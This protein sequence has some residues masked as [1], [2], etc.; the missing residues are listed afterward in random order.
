MDAAPLRYSCFAI[1]LHWVMALAFLLMLASGLVM[2][3]LDIP[4]SLQFQIY[5]WHKS[6]GVLLLLA[7]FLRLAV[8]LRARVPEL[9][10]RMKPFE[11][12]AAKAGH[13][14]LYVWMIALPLTGWLVVSASPFG[15]PTIVF[16]WFEW[17]H[18]PDLAGN[19]PVSEFAETAHQWLAYAFIALIAGHVAAV[20]KHYLI[21]KENLLPRMGI[22]RAK[23]E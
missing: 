22:G 20:V 8:R 15:L 2:A 10:V 14:A 4:K 1:A 17:P 23:G 6:L 9:P 11:K 5:Q 3:N 19:E 16:G 18:I 21:D 7:F 12:K 13:F